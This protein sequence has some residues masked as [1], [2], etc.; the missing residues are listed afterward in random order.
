MSYCSLAL[1]LLVLAGA[2]VPP[3]SARL[4]EEV[5][6]T[7]SRLP[8]GGA[9]RRVLVLT[10]EEIAQLPVTTL[11]E[12]LAYLVG[13]GVARRGAGGLQTDAALRGA[14]FEQVAVLVDGVRV[15]DPQTGHF[16]LD[17][18]LP[19]EAIARVEVLLGPGSAV[20]GPDAFGGVIAVTTATSLGAAVGVKIGQFG[21]RAG[22]LALPLGQRGWAAVE[23]GRADGFAPNT[24][25]RTVRAAAGWSGQGAGWQARAALGWEDKSFGAWNFYT[26]RFP[27]QYEETGTALAT[28]S[29]SRPVGSALLTLR[30]AA[31]QHRDYF[32]L[33][34]PRPQWYANRHRSRSGVVQAS[35]SGARG[36]SA[37]VAGVEGARD[38]LA[39]TRLGHRERDRVA[40]FCE[41]SHRRSRLAGHGQLR[42]EHLR[43]V[44]WQVSPAAGAE[45]DVAS[46]WQ[47]GAAVAHS[48]RLPS[49]T[50]LYYDS[51]TIVGNPQ[52]KAEKGWTGEFAVRRQGNAVTWESGVFARRARH[53]ID[54]LADA[55]QIYRATNHAAITTRGM[56]VA[57]L[58]PAL[59]PLRQ[60]RA[61]ASVVT[62]RLAVDPA[63][64]RYALAHPH[65]EASLAALVPLPWGV[66]LAGGVRLRNPRAAASYALFDVRLRR[67]VVADLEAQ[68]EVTN[69]LDR[70]Y[71]EVPGVP[72]P[73]RWATLSLTWRPHD[74][75]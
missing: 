34:R 33:D 15:N 22:R 25:W 45:W 69:A 49:F 24:D 26:T 23:G 8:E 70:S 55:G 41:L 68:L 59:G 14:T 10:R 53:L 30:A 51:P 64:S 63:R 13:G 52:L 16:H 73:G 11:P 1:S 60:V 62:S 75:R 29:A 37:W 12:L 21:E 50:E 32:V 6:V 72:L 5:T 4:V 27:Q 20:H 40:A 48:F 39:S 65:W 2:P 36:A 31:R 71:Q 56:E 38:T 17:L 18:P 74:A 61:A 57:L 44:G 47:V 7:A 66:E 28:A 54:Y 19:V 43:G 42:L 3:P 35:L 58:A 9:G 46:G 67:A